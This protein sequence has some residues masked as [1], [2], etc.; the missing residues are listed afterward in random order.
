MENIMNGWLSSGGGGGIG[1]VNFINVFITRVINVFVP[2]SIYG[3]LVPTTTNVYSVGTLDKMWT[4]VVSLGTITGNVVPLSDNQYTLGTPTARWA[5]IQVGPGTLFMTDNVTGNQ[6]GITISNNA[7]L[8]NGA[9]SLRIGAVTFG[10]GT[11]QS[12]SANPQ[13]VRIVPAPVN[14]V[15]LDMS[16]DNIVHCHVTSGALSVT[17][18]NFTAGKTVELLAFWDATTSGGSISINGISGSNVS[19]G[20]NGFSITK[21]FNSLRVYSAD[22]TAGNTFCVATIS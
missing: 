14:A 22:G 15:T 2:G 1:G 6:A 19:N 13:R 17:I 11:V 4:N 16:V 20:N 5:N 10:D 7:L 8:V 21:Q 18:T 9:Q 3:S 12:T